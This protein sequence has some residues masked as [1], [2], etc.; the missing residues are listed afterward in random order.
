[1]STI[2]TILGRGAKGPIYRYHESGQARNM[3]V[4]IAQVSTPRPD[5]PNQYHAIGNYTITM[6][7]AEDL[8]LSVN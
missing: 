2:R 8:S 5:R 3:C 4:C 7:P 1:M 6:E